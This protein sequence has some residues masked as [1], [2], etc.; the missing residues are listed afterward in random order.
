M[1]ILLFVNILVMIF[2]NSYSFGNDE[3][4]SYYEVSQLFNQRAGRVACDFLS[5]ELARIKELNEEEIREEFLESSSHL[6]NYLSST[7]ELREQTEFKKLHQEIKKVIQHPFLK[8]RTISMIEKF[9]HMTSVP[10]R[11]GS[12]GIALG[13]SAILHTAGFPV[14]GMFHFMDGFLSRRKIK[15]G[16]RNDF[17]LRAFGPKTNVARVFLSIVS[18]EIMSS[19]LGQGPGLSVANASVVIEM[20]TNFRCFNLNTK[21]ENLVNFC[22]AYGDLRDFFHQGHGKIFKAGKR[23]Q[24]LIDQ[25][26]IQRRQD[27]SPGDFCQYSPKKQVRTAKRV[28]Q[29]HPEFLEDERINGVKIIPPIHKNACTKILFQVKK[30][31]DLES[32]TLE[33][34]ILEGIEL[35]FSLKNDFPQNL[36]FSSDELRSMGPM[37]AYCYEAESV[38][39]GNELQDEFRFFSDLLKSA[40]APSLL[41]QPSLEEILVEDKHLRRTHPS[42]HLSALRNIIFSV[43]PLE[44][45]ESK[46]R[47]LITERDDLLFKIRKNYRKTMSAGSFSRCKKL[48]QNLGINEEE[49]TKSLTRISELDQNKLIK[50]YTEF[51]LVE[52]LFKKEKKRLKLSWELMRTNDLDEVMRALRSKDVAHVII[53]AHGRDSGH[54]IDTSG[55]EF[56]R[57]TFTN[58]SPSVQS[59]NFYSCYSKKLL[60]LYRLGENLK[61]LPSHYKTRYLTSVTE[62]EFMDKTNLAPIAAFGYYLNRLDRFFY[63]SMKGAEVL[64]G[65]FGHQLRPIEETKMCQIDAS[66]VEVVKGTYAVILNDEFISTIGVNKKETLLDYPCDLLRSQEVNQLTLKSIS[67]N[68]EVQIQNL[69]NLSID[70]NHQ[71]LSPHLRFQHL[72]VFKFSGS[73]H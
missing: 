68:G 3:V 17:L 25:K 33:Q 65:M 24:Y 14:L 20:I 45:E 49:F 63:R 47:E 59:I 29:R 23:F 40:Y 35:H 39:Y 30:P 31:Q 73:E 15:L 48:F 70:I 38:Y 32:I 7:D 54:V 2:V 16:K 9:C 53:M 64:Q 21:D 50:K 34:K 37:D 69:Q 11:H 46:A 60:N 61:E 43:G 8:S 56:P 52:K 26:I 5:T 58:I 27:L 66:K 12:R 44:E 28:L 18:S 22:I 51:R 13:N 67:T 72:V 71:T 19:I 4:N 55:E 36:L 42:S 1:K 57:E 10:I 62:N 6:E 41:A